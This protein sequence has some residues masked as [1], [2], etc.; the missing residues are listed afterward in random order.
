MRWG[1]IPS[2][3]L[4]D[5]TNEGQLR[6][7]IHEAR[8]VRCEARPEI[9]VAEGVGIQR[10]HAAFVIVREKFGFVGG[11]VDADGAIAFAAFAGQA[12]IERVF[13]FFAAPAVA[14]DGVVAIGI[15]RHLPEQV[16]A[17]ASGVLF[18]VRGALTGTHHAAFFAAAF[19]NANAAKSR[20]RKA[21]VIQRKLEMRLGLPGRV[22]RT[23]AKIFVELV[24][25][26]SR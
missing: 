16:S 22:V 2:D 10:A 1:G 6:G 21:A 9:D 17:A 8:S 25:R 26:L 20:M 15:L 5:V 19:A 14:D 18:F 12:E 7:E 4:R 11:D 24:R 13:D 3:E 23:E